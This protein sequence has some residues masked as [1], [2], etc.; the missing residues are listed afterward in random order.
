MRLLL[1]TLA[2]VLLINNVCAVEITE[3]FRGITTSYP[4]PPRAYWIH[5]Y[6][7]APA[8]PSSESSPP[9][10]ATEFTDAD[11]GQIA[12]LDGSYYYY[13]DA[14]THYF[15]FRIPAGSSAE[16]HWYG[17]ANDGNDYVYLYAFNWTSS[18]WE[19]LGS[20]YGN[21]WGWINAT[22]S[23]DHISGNGYVHLAFVGYRSSSAD[24]AAEFP[25]DYVELVVDVTQ[26]TPVCVDVLSSSVRN[27]DGIF[28]TDSV[29]V[30]ARATLSGSTVEW[31]DNFSLEAE[32]QEGSANI[33][34]SSFSVSQ[35]NATLSGRP[36]DG[37]V[38]DRWRVKFAVSAGYAIVNGVAY[39]P[40]ASCGRE[41]FAENVAVT[42]DS[43]DILLVG[44]R[45]DN[46]GEDW[47][48]FRWVA[49]PEDV[50]HVSKDGYDVPVAQ[51]FRNWDLLFWKIGVPDP[52]HDND[53]LTEGVYGTSNDVNYESY[54]ACIGP[55]RSPSDPRYCGY[56]ICQEDGRCCYNDVDK[57]HN[58][59]LHLSG[60]RFGPLIEI[61]A[62]DHAIGV[63]V[64][65]TI[66][67]CANL[68][69]IPDI[70]AQP[71]DAHEGGGEG[72]EIHCEVLDVGM[73]TITTELAFKQGYNILGLL[74]IFDADPHEGFGLP[75]FVGL[76]AD[77]EHVVGLVLG[78]RFGI[79]PFVALVTTMPRSEIPSFDDH[80]NTTAKEIWQ[81]SEFYAKW[82]YYILRNTAYIVKVTAEEL[83]NW[84]KRYP[85]SGEDNILLA[86]RVL[87]DLFLDLLPYLKEVLWTIRVT[88]NNTI[89]TFI[90]TTYTQLHGLFRM[91]D[92]IRSDVTLRSEFE[93]VVATFFAS[94]PGIFGPPD[95]STGLSYL[96]KHRGSLTYDE[97][98]SF[99]QKLFEM[100]DTGLDLLIAVMKNLPLMEV[101]ADPY[102][103][104]W[105]YG[106]WV[107]HGH[108]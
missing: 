4:Y 54:P 89:N 10:G 14:E 27:W 11:Y 44:R 68:E 15:I 57:D 33:P 92:T 93:N 45:W 60:Y 41:V 101:R 64:A 69:T 75:G 51:R 20:F 6:D 23:D 49:D 76:M 72:N 65:N 108:T 58:C 16:V 61:N 81:S 35:Q 18:G 83:A 103:P 17:H 30:T 100:A 97:K 19:Q 26:F 104:G 66:D 99:A 24:D 39:G 8:A 80:T 74:W 56:Y 96:L 67:I 52:N 94:V 9:G 36:V 82:I 2:L 34:L 79:H 12:Y 77:R 102:F 37:G 5:N 95:G 32:W 7:S 70:L 53:G 22:L 59:S 84:D 42:P 91:I 46:T 3:N 71:Y 63:V 62:P 48:V 13:G 43:Y 98:L 88:G 55:D 25:T 85:P 47:V 28:D 50:E 31:Y 87:N 78:H 21:S 90:I 105:N 40:D 106:D 73:D 1:L 38:T 86:N 29:S 107:A